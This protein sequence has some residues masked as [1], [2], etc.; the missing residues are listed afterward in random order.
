M[1]N[2]RSLRESIKVSQTYSPENLI[3]KTLD[4]LEWQKQA[5]KIAE[6]L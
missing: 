4:T 1:R 2:R 6:K 3:Q 5:I